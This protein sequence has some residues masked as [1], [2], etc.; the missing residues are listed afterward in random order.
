MGIVH[1]VAGKPIVNSEDK[2][3]WTDSLKAD[4][5]GRSPVPNPQFGVQ[6]FDSVGTQRPTDLGGGNDLVGYE[7]C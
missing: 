2:Y 5:T 6:V 4:T 3:I 7:I 1:I